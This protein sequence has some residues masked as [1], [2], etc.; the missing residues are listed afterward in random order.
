MVVRA[1][2]IMWSSVYSRT[3]PKPLITL[4]MNG[5]TRHWTT[6]ERIGSGHKC[7]R[8][9]IGNQPQKQY[10]RVVRP[11]INSAIVRFQVQDVNADGLREW[12]TISPC[13]KQVDMKIKHMPWTMN[14]G[15]WNVL[16]LYRTE[17][18]T[19]MVKELESRDMDITTV[20]KIRYTGN[21]TVEASQGK[22]CGVSHTS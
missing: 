17:S 18:W 10:W 13:Q 3:S 7:S 19:Q 8:S 12:L 9:G 11:H 1:V 22:P 15:T 14:K 20:Q 6:L 21:G 5:T 2:P 16:S 4:Y